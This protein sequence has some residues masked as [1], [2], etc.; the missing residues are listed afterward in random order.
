MEILKVH[1]LSKVYGKGET[2]IKALDDVSFS[3]EKGEFVAIVGP[4]GSGKSTLLHILGLLDRPSSGQYLFAGVDTDTLDD[5]RLAVLRNRAIG[6]VFQSFNLVSGESAL[7]NADF[8]KDVVGEAGND[9]AGKA[10][11]KAKHGRY[12]FGTKGEYREGCGFACAGRD[13]CSEGAE[14]GEC[15]TCHRIQHPLVSDQ[16]ENDLHRRG[17]AATG[18]S[19]RAEPGRN[20]APTSDQRGWCW[21]RV[22]LLAKHA[23]N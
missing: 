20:L 7:E 19:G 6:F 2:Q 14:M 3:V 22:Y 5:D 18:R 13:C 17:A 1:N 11:H 4:S 23:E 16:S 10:S 8:A 12:A 21:I 15:I 9:D